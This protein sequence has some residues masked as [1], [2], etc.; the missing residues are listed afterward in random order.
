MWKDWADCSFQYPN[1]RHMARWHRVTTPPFLFQQCLYELYGAL[2]SM[3][4]A[5]DMLSPQMTKSTIRNI[6]WMWPNHPVCMAY[7]R[8]MVTG[9]NIST[10]RLFA[11]VQQGGGVHPTILPTFLSSWGIKQYCHM[12]TQPSV[13]AEQSEAARQTPSTYNGEWGSATT[14]ATIFLFFSFRMLFRCAVP[15]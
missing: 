8:G 7:W 10:S 3:T 13:L 14:P 1:Q 12:V 9:K 6:Q 2:T 15:W 4:F 11:S 5:E